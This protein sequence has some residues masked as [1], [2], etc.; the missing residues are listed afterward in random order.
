MKKLYMFL[1]AMIFAVT[2][3]LAD[4]MS[5]QA[6]TEISTEHPH[7]II[8]V[9][10]IRD[11]MLDNIEL[12]VGDIL[13][14]KMLNVTEPQR[15]KRDASF[16]FYPLN[17][18]DNAGKQK[19]IGKIYVGSY[20][21]HFDIDA[22]KLA[23]NTVLIVGNHFVKGVSAGYYAVEGAVKNEDDNR[24]KSAAENVYENSPLSYVE[25]GEQLNIKPDTCFG[26]KFD[27]CKNLQKEDG[28]A[29]TAQ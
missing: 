25:K 8:K 26:L 2:P 29:K 20:T 7:S 17:Y 9:R 27:A 28:A 18:T 15:L 4:T 24:L 21:P 1:V 13:E 11:C 5:V 6:V 3:V 23:K 22:K 16:T 10:V 19:H 14:G 12:K